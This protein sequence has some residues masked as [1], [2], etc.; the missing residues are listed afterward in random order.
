MLRTMGRAA[1]AVT[2]A[3]L[4]FGG[5]RAQGATDVVPTQPMGAHMEITL[6]ASPAQGD[7]QRAQAVV[8]AARRLMAQYPTTADAERAGFAKFL[9]RVPLPIE[10]YTNR[11][12]AATAAFGRFDPARPTS[13]IFQRSGG[14]LHP[15][16][17]MYTAPNSATQAQLDAKVPLSVAT[18]HRH[19]NF[20]VPAHGTPQSE[21]SGPGA[22]FF[23]GSIATA[24]ACRAAGGWFVPRVFGWM[25]HVW[26][27]ET[28]PAKIWAVDRGDGMTSGG[29]MMGG[30]TAH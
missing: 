7:A 21:T 30:M 24:D 28:D 13:L 29:A 3:L 20:C 4:T 12:N 6:H 10:H 23:F 17:V 22:R 8:D 11:A 1:A 9:P 15:V 14:E 26:P 16:G 5:L 19:V 25:V 2:I 18:W 27:L